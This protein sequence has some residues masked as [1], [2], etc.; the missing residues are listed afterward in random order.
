METKTG[1]EIEGRSTY[2]Q[3]NS[4]VMR[5]KMHFQGSLIES[6]WNSRHSL[7]QTTFFQGWRQKL[8]RKSR[9]DQLIHSGIPG[10]CGKK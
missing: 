8:A 1:K 6:A 10:S 3:W 7:L 2:S 9:G 5:K 4:G